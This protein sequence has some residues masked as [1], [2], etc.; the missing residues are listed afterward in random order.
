MPVRNSCQMLIRTALHCTSLS[1]AARLPSTLYL[2]HRRSKKI[3][4]RGYTGFF[5]SSSDPVVGQTAR[6]FLTRPEAL[7]SGWL[8]LRVPSSWRVWRTRETLSGRQPPVLCLFGDTRLVVFLG[9]IQKFDFLCHD[10]GQAAEKKKLRNF[11]QR[12]FNKKNIYSVDY[13]TDRLTAGVAGSQVVYEQ[14]SCAI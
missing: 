8:P 6:V 1:G 3:V 9:W 10:S 14:T 5:L 4:T 2:S 13:D 7:R 12:R 11:L